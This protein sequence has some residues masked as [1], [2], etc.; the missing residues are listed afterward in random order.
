MFKSKGKRP[1][2]MRRPFAKM[3]AKPIISR[4][5]RRRTIS[6]ARCYG[7]SWD[8]RFLKQQLLGKD[9]VF[10]DEPFI[11]DGYVR[12]PDGP[13]L[14]ILRWSEHTWPLVRGIGNEE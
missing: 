2:V 10:Y 14:N 11:R 13:D 12:V 1:C 6:L 9:L 3:D 4:V 5:L 8:Y 7:R